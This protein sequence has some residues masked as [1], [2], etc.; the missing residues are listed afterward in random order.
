MWREMERLSMEKDTVGKRLV[1]I[2]ER[3]MWTQARLAEEAGVSPTTV[4]G[5][6]SGRI[7]R[8][9]FGTL[10]KLAR[11]LGVEPEELVSGGRAA[12]GPLSLEWAM[13]SGEGE[14]QLGLEGATVE[15][16][17][18]LSRDLGEAGGRGDQVRV[19]HNV[20]ERDSL[21]CYRVLQGPFEVARVR[22]GVA[23][24]A[25]ASG[26]S[27]EVDGPVLR[28]RRPADVA[29]LVH[30]YGP[31][32]P[33][34]EDDY[35]DADA[36]ADGRLYLLAG[37]QEP[38]VAA[39]RDDLPL[40]GR[41]LR[42]DGA[43]HAVTH[44]AVGGRHLGARVVVAP[45]AVQ[46]DR[47]VARVV[48]Q[49]RVLGQDPAEHA[50]DLGGVYPGLRPA[51]RGPAELQ[52]GPVGGRPVAFDR[53]RGAPGEG[54]EGRAHVRDD[55]ALY[56]DRGAD[57]VGVCVHLDHGLVPAREGVGLGGDLAQAAPD[58]DDE[59][60]LFERPEGL[61]PGREGEVPQVEGV[62]VREDV[63]AAEAGVDPGP[64]RFGEPD[65]GLAG[66][67]RAAARDHDGPPRRDQPARH[68]LHILGVGR[69]AWPAFGEAG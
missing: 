45:V 4:S 9:H 60:G 31:V 34:A 2:R 52:V 63:L 20:H 7:S 1:V 43:G 51:R 38:P 17:S 33:V 23:R 61:G 40:R 54:I 69:R 26:E 16:L 13:S 67:P 30:G 59:V 24:G 44:S 12:P 25:E 3:R 19:R 21:V 42:A 27:G 46:K 58:H 32:H 55:A 35:R 36:V 18:S 8:P 53:L 48:S 57:L 14:F 28:P 49:D 6:E 37:H 56:R 22:D 29:G 66:V 68:V 64:V 65:E 10:R 39:E 11:A 41:E 47:E 15:G 50:D 5:I 62:P